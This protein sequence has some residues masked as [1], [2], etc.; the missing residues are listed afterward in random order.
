MAFVLVTEGYIAKVNRHM[1]GFCKIWVTDVNGNYVAG[2][3]NYHRCDLDT[4]FSI[5]TGSSDAYYLNAHVKAS[6]K[7]TKHRGPFVAD[8][9]MIFVVLRL[10]G[11]LILTNIANNTTLIYM[12]KHVK[13]NNSSY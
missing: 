9:A 4:R 12:D 7:K 13:I 2:N 8:A 6:T 1:G 5:D 11:H 3:K 10:I